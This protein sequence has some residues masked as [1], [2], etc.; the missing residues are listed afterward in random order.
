[1]Y[2]KQGQ[3][4]SS[5]VL[6]G[7]G[8]MFLDN[9][10]PYRH[11]LKY[12]ISFSDYLAV[13]SRI[14]TVMRRDPHTGNDGK[15]LIQS[16]YFDNYRDKALREKKDGLQRREKFRIRYY[17][18]DMSFITLE[19]KI[20]QN[21]LCIKYG[22]K[23]SRED[24]EM[25]IKGEQLHVD[26]NEKPLV[27]ELIIKMTTELLRPR[28][29]VSYTREPYIYPAGNVRVT[30]DSDIRSSLYGKDFINDP[31]AGINAC[32]DTRE[33]I[34]EVKYD[35]FLPEIIALLIQSGNVRQQSFSKYGICRRFG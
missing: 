11:E 26:I 30:F 24:F 9:K 15:Y 14:K 29:L 3:C 4:R 21:N 16:V 35:E 28:V 19:K 12:S 6:P 23:I 5:A 18:S 2:I 8:E 25:I 7:K 27:K 33:I 20:K 1:M 22:E 17:N 13:K 32:E 34:M 10:I 31:F